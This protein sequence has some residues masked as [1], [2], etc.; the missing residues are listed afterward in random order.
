M[1]DLSGTMPRAGRCP[2]WLWVLLVLSLA[3]NLALAGAVAGRL[4]DRMTR[5]DG[6]GRFEAA[7]VAALPEARRA[8]ARAILADGTRDPQAFRA[9]FV[10]SSRAVSAALA[11]EPFD[12]GAL[13]AAMEARRALFSGRWAERQERFL[14]LADALGAAERAELARKLQERTERRAERW[15]AR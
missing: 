7:I 8:E 11:A 6:L 4:L 14:R 12:R 10:D 5:A 9:A 13:E 15:A 3:V 1:A 2:R